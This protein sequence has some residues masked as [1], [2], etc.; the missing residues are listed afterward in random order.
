M[1]T[2]QVYTM[3]WSTYSHIVPKIKQEMKKKIRNGAHIFKISQRWKICV[4][5]ICYGIHW[6]FFLNAVWADC[7]PTKR[8]NGSFLLSLCSRPVRIQIRIIGFGNGICEIYMFRTCGATHEEGEM[9]KKTRTFELPSP[10][11][12]LSM[13]TIL[14]RLNISHWNLLHFFPPC[15]LFGVVLL[16]ERLAFISY[17]ISYSF[18]GF[19]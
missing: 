6:I 16:R 14:L 17:S 5:P 3:F 15:E 1:R 8:K 9:K 12:I 19:V 11:R 10:S 2:I 18:N 4:Q 13:N 7:E